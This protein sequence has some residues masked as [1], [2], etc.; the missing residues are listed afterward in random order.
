MTPTW[1]SSVFVAAVAVRGVTAG[2]IIGLGLM[3]IPMK[4][5]V[6]VEVHARYQAAMYAGR[7]PR[8]YGAATALAEILL[9]ALVWWAWDSGG[10][11]AKTFLSGAVGFTALGFVGTAFSLR[12]MRALTGGVLR[13]DDATAAVTSFARWHVYGAFCHG[14]AF[15]ALAVASPFI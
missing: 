1:V 14:L 2:V 5:R 10:G 9:I 8:I 4:D 12:A 15:V 11:W 6:G 7:G 3:M 13:G